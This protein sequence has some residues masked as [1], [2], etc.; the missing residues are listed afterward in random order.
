VSVLPVPNLADRA[1][2][3]RVSKG[4]G[5]SVPRHAPVR[6]WSPTVAPRSVAAPNCLEYPSSRSARR[7]L[8]TQTLPLV[9]L[10]TLRPIPGS[11]SFQESCFANLS[12]ART[13]SARC[14]DADPD[15]AKQNAPRSNAPASPARQMCSDPNRIL[16]SASR[17]NSGSLVSMASIRQ[18]VRMFFLPP[19]SRPTSTMFIN[20]GLL[21]E[22]RVNCQARYRKDFFAVIALFR[23]GCKICMPA[24]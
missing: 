18:K 19:S 6:R 21:C 11:V 14:F 4:G 17:T 5:A 24:S 1:S 16:L 2:P 22:A 9:R 7:F 8:R 10:K 13:M 23:E 20:K 12:A 3:A 15:L